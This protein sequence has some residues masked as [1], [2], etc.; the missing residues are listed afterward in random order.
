MK[1]AITIAA[2]GFLYAWGNFGLETAI[3]SIL[4]SFCIGWIMQDLS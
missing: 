1:F 4:P 2:I 3:V